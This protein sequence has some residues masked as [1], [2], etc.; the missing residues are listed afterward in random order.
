MTK[1][2]RLI[3]TDIKI[4]NGRIQMYVFCQIF[5]DGFVIYLFELWC[6]K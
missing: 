1:F 5:I 3:P 2:Y 6:W 4:F